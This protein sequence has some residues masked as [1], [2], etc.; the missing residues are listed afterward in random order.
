MKIPKLIL[1]GAGPGDV[2]LIT[3]KGIK[4]I[5]SADV[6]LYD[7]LANP[8]LLKYA[9]EEALKI[10]VGKK[11]SMHIYTQHSINEMIV[12]YAHKLGTVV[13]LKGGDPFVFGRGHEEME[14]ANTS[15]VTST[16]VRGA[17]ILRSQ[18]DSRILSSATPSNC[19]VSGFLVKIP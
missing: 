8:E 12:D 3:M 10:Y 13:R 2:D 7:A 18:G 14:Y 5:Q 19:N 17:S 6:I 1:V 16:S 11:A 15:L 9:T 4:A